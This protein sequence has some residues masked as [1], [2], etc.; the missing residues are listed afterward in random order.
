[1]KIYQRL[2][3]LVAWDPPAG[4]EFEDRKYRE[5]DGLIDIAPHGSGLDGV[6]IINEYK[7]SDRGIEIKT[8]YHY[9]DS[10]GF[11]GTWLNLTISIIPVLTPAGYEVS[12]KCAEDIDL[13]NTICQEEAHNYILLNYPEIDLEGPEYEEL[14]RE[15]SEYIDWD[16]IRDY[17]ADCFCEWLDSEYKG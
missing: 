7:S 16:S 1:M 13:S 3:E 8:V 6:T 14:E 15:N 10:N 12:I 11:Y 17:V 2:A 9:M 5:L 4:S